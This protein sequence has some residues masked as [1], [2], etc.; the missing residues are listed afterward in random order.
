MHAF[1]DLKVDLS[2]E[3]VAVVGLGNVALDVARILL[4]PIDFLKRTDITERALAAIAES[5][6]KRVYIVGRRGP[7]HVSFTIKELREMVNL[8]GCRP[9]LDREDFVGVK[10]AVPSLKRP[11][12]R[13]T[14]LL[15][16]TALDEPSEKVLQRSMSWG[17]KMRTVRN[18]VHTIFFMFLPFLGCRTQG[19]C[20][21]VLAPE[22]TQDSVGDTPWWR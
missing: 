10:E 3:S 13:L 8:A 17:H 14:E 12:K 9:V 2:H 5:R 6:V 21:K 22:A 20:R 19:Q 11:R 7:L 16:K 1:S 15:A 18:L 4:T